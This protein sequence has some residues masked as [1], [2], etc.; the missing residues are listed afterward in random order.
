MVTRADALNR[1]FTVHS[2]R[3]IVTKTRHLLTLIIHDKEVPLY[4][5]LSRLKYSMW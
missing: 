2:F 1:S 3:N 5:S 4:T